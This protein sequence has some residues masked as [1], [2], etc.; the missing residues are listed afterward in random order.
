MKTFS[1][2][3]L[4]VFLFSS[5]VAVSQSDTLQEFKYGKKNHTGFGIAVKAGTLGIGLE[6]V[7][8]FNFPLNLRLG[9]SFFKDNRD[10]SVYVSDNAKT[11]NH[12]TL[13]SISLLADWQLGGAFHITAGAFYNF[14]EETIDVTSN[15]SAYVDDIEL[16][17]ETLGTVSTNI[18]LSKVNPYF[19]IGFGRSIS[20]KSLVGFGIDLGAMYI[21]KPK[22][23]LTASGMAEPTAEPYPTE[24]GMT[25]NQEVIEGNIENF[26]FYPYINF[27]LS[28]RITGRK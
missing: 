13:G 16:T 21:G 9:G 6:I 26:I 8:A 10:I 25:S 27:Q 15:E 17:P 5:F 7:K 19:G 12:L 23:Y 2:S 24:D 28:F 22:V 11:V 1:I 18:K 14:S 20:K 3:L 4:F